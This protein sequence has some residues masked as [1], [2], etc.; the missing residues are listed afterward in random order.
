MLLTPRAPSTAVEGA[1]WL[2]ELFEK[3]VEVV[4]PG[5]RLR[6]FVRPD[7][8]GRALQVVAGIVEQRGQGKSLCRRYP[9][10][11]GLV[12]AAVRIPDVWL[13]VAYVVD[14][15]A[16][17]HLM[18]ARVLDLFG[19]VQELREREMR[20][21]AVPVAGIDVLDV[22]FAVTQNLTSKPLDS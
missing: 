2:C 3:L 21:E 10:V 16:E 15:G 20:L 9:L 14:M 6:H 12:E 18:P 13:D 1:L 11:A 22:A 19:L 8:R 17:A 7:V 5:G 4:G